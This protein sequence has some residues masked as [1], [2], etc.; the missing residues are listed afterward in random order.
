MFMLIVN[1]SILFTLHIICYDIWYYIIHYLMH[2][3]QC[4]FIHK[5]HHKNLPNLLTY[6]D[7]YTGNIIEFPLETAGIFMP[8]III[9]TNRSII[10]F[11]ILFIFIRN[12]MQ[13]DK[14]FV[15]IVGDHHLLHHRYPFCNYGEYWIDNLFGT[16][17]YK[18]L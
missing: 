12:L 7:A 11:S 13:H 2:T 9:E 17:Y 6:K 1:N 5:L 16:N 3:R 18:K 4:Y 15:W 14:R 10:F 8:C